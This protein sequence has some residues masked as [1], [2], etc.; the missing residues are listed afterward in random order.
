[1]NS[2]FAYFS[3]WIVPI[4]TIGQRSGKDLSTQIPQSWVTLRSV[5]Y[6]N[7]GV[8][9]F[10]KNC[11][12]LKIYAPPIAKYTRSPRKSVPWLS[13]GSF[14][15]IRFLGLHSFGH[16]IGKTRIHPSSIIQLIGRVP[17]YLKIWFFNHF[18]ATSIAFRQNDDFGKRVKFGPRRRRICWNF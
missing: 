4:L 9:I 16:R 13:E 11:Q 18:E 6:E 10:Q 15:K 1:M 2:T 17:E 8:Q 7:A 12:I 5:S 14:K 3:V